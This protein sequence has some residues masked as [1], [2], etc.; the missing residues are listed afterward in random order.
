MRLI[1]VRKKNGPIIGFVEKTEEI[2]LI[3]E[4]AEL[5]G[6]NSHECQYAE[7]DLPMGGIFSKTSN[8]DGVIYP[9]WDT[10]SSIGLMYVSESLGDNVADWNDLPD[11]CSKEARDAAVYALN[12]PE[13]IF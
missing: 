10:F 9:I 8:E 11:I 2:V 3:I 4:I 5:A 13:D 6:I 1:L 7:A 12:T